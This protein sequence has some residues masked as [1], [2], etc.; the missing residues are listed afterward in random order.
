MPAP[1][2]PI[3]AAAASAIGSAADSAAQ[4]RTSL[5]NTRMTIAAN[6]AEAELAWQ[7]NQQMWHMQNLYNSPEAQMRRFKEAGLNPHLIYGQGTPGNAVGPPAYSPPDIKY[8]FEAP[9][10]GQAAASVIPMLMEV[11]SWMQDMRLGEAQIDKTRTETQRS[12]SENERLRQLLMFL[13]QRNPQILKEG[14]NKLS[15]FPYQRQMQDYQTN[16]ARTK[17]FELEQ[18]FRYKFGESLFSEM[19]SAWEP[20]GGKFS[21]AGGTKRLE[22]LQEQAKTK[23]EEAR[24]SWSEFDITNPQAIVQLVLSGI[25]GMAGSTLRLSSHRGSK[26]S[27]PK[28][29]RPRGLNHRRM[30]KQ[31]PDNPYRVGFDSRGVPIQPGYKRQR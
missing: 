25:M 2:I 19:G 29:E 7:R 21:P 18:E 3:I 26:A 20:A 17:L 13:E 12:V 11:G 1:L 14:S 4:R 27:T 23:L 6:K 16:A 8:Q 28:R 24:A 10:Y 31:H 9:K 22:F 30:E 15:L 5:G